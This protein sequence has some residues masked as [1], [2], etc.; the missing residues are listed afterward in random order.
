MDS[1]TTKPKGNAMMGTPPESE[2]AG[3]HSIILRTRKYRLANFEN[4]RRRFRGRNVRKLYL[5]V[6]TLFF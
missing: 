6:T 2:M 5:L 1:P 3:K 4:C